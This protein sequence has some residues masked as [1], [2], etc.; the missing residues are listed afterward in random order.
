MQDD[1]RHQKARAPGLVERQRRHDP[2]AAERA[3]KA[4]ARL[5]ITDRG[6]APV[7]H[8]L[9]PRRE[10]PQLFHVKCPVR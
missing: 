1:R 10:I 5:C 2:F 7:D 6:R 8:K 4:D 9:R 3:G